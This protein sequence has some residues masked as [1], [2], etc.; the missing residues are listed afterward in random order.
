MPL[1]LQILVSCEHARNR[2]PQPYQHLFTDQEAVL[3]SHRGYDLG[4]LP[5]A[6]ML[7]AEFGSPLICGDVTRLMVDLNRSCK[8]KNLFSEFTQGLPIC[9]RL[10]ILR[11]YH[12]PYWSTVEDIAAEIIASNRRVLHLSVHSFTPV[13]HGKIR[14]ADIGLLY[15]PARPAEKTWCL[16]WQQALSTSHPGLRIRRNYPYRGNADALVT[17]LRR[18]FAAENYLGVE[19]EINQQIPLERP[20]LWST[21]QHQ[22]IASL[23]FVR[24]FSEDLQ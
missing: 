17:A 16:Q 12:H 23:H 4:I 13:L 15:D 1:P 21:I 3:E 18:R 10:E 22:L 2:V 14:N 19:L 6:E 11:R 5:F 7:A 20:L 9:E 24:K 8:S